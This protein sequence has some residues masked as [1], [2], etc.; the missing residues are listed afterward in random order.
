[1]T[2]VRE[3]NRHL[4]IIEGATL[5]ELVDGLNSIGATPRDLISILRTMQVSGAL[6]AELEVI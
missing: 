4:I 2:N 3:E 6:L 5:Q 1:E